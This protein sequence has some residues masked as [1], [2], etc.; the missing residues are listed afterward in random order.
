MSDDLLVHEGRDHAPCPECG[1]AVN[2]RVRSPVPPMLRHE[3]E[4]CGQSWTPWEFSR[5]RLAVDALHCD[6][7]WGDFNRC[8][9]SDRHEPHMVK[10]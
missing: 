10:P 8:G 6:G 2:R 5:A 7:T 9:N 4:V 1:G 3:C